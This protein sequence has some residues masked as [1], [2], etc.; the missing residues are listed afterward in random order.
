MM[1]NW[2]Q[3]LIPVEV[4]ILVLLDRIYSISLCLGLF[5]VL[6]GTLHLVFG[7]D[8]FIKSKALMLMNIYGTN[9]F[10][11]ALGIFQSL[12]WQTMTAMVLVNTLISLI[13]HSHFSRGTILRKAIRNS[14]RENMFVSMGR[15]TNKFIAESKKDRSEPIK[16]ETKGRKINTLENKNKS[17]EYNT[18]PRSENEFGVKSGP[19]SVSESSGENRQKVTN[20]PKGRDKTKSV[21][22]QK[23]ENTPEVKGEPGKKV[24]AEEDPI[25]KE[26]DMLTQKI[27]EQK[28][29]LRKK[30]ETAR[31]NAY[32]T[33][34]PE[35]IEKTE[36]IIK[37]ILDKYDLTEESLKDGS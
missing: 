4:D 30:I 9:S 5:F 6:L 29:I 11:V 26:N 1:L 33:R 25:K 35:E 34:K 20:N 2:H 18:A 27:K 3:F 32:V 16:N 8:I 37:D 28:K 13:L 14:G 7:K 12:R 24:E 19:K 31:R 10:V 21:G 17:A 22:G 15:R 23:T 36:K